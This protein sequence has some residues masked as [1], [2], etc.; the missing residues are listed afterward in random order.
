[1][2]MQNMGISLFFHIKTITLDQIQIQNH[3][4]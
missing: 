2:K 4:T 3:Y 1:M